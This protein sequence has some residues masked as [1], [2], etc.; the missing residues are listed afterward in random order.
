[1][2]WL[3]ADS[4]ERRK[5]GGKGGKAVCQGEGPELDC[6]GNRHCPGSANSFLSPTPSP[7]VVVVVV[8]E[9]WKEGGGVGG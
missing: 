3:I 9:G 1:M 5:G 8:R 7:L 2:S 6:E 4:S